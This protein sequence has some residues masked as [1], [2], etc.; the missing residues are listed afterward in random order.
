MP[1][2]VELAPLGGLLN[3]GQVKDALLEAGFHFVLHGHA[4]SAWLV[5]ERW[6][7]KHGGRE[8][9][10]IAAPTLSSDETVESHGYNELCIHFE[11]DGPRVDV[12]LY[13]RKGD[14]FHLTDQQTIALTAK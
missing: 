4:H 13:E 12:M 11:V 6:F 1:S 8:L 10:V 3:A 7:R 14:S 2:S 9:H 5:A